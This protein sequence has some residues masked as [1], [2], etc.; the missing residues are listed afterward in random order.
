MSKAK[1]GWI[2]PMT[3][4]KKMNVDA[5]VAKSDAKG[6]VGV[7]CRSREGEYLGASAIVFEALTNLA[8]LEALA[9]REVLDLVADLNIRPIQVATDCLE[10]IKRLQGKYLGVFSNVLHQIRERSRQR[11]DTIFSHE[12]REANKETHRLVRFS[13]MLPPLWLYLSISVLGH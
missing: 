10:V 2:A 1:G 6:S 13:T 12:R 4:W 7:V 8:C 3:V 5:A 9:C 11:G